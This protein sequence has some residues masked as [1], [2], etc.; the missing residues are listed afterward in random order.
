[1][2]KNPPPSDQP[3]DA[4]L[5]DREVVIPAHV[6]PDLS[7]Q[8]IVALARQRIAAISSPTKVLNVSRKPED[9]RSSGPRDGGR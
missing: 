1:M 7:A 6:L 3:L 5:C 8:E 2:K 9:R 4:Y